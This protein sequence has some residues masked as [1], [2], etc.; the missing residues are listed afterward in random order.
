[1]GDKSEIYINDGFLKDTEAHRHP[2]YN[3]ATSILRADPNAVHTV[4]DGFL[5]MLGYRG[6]MLARAV[7]C[8]GD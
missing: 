6:S 1:M 7:A 4:P 5:D 3:S 8:H 2:K